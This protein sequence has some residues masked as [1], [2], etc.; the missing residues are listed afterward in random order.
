VFLA[1]HAQHSHL[2]G[3]LA[4]ELS[5]YLRI[6]VS[7]TRL[8]E[9]DIKLP[10]LPPSCLRN[11]S[12]PREELISCRKQEQ[13]KILSSATIL[14]HVSHSSTTPTI[15]MSK[16]QSSKADKAYDTKSISESSIFS[17]KEKAWKEYEDAQ[18]SQKK[19][20]TSRLIESM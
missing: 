13:S 14:S 18:K 8:V 9:V 12:F 1:A 7:L 20:K 10:Q 6:P 5:E 2:G 19:S 4:E 17:E 15:S 3:H 11:T 16:Q